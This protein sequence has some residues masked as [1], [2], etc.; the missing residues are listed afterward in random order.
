MHTVV[1]AALALCESFRLTTTAQILLLLFVLRKSLARV[2][3]V[4][5]YLRYDKENN[6]TAVVSVHSK[7]GVVRGRYFTGTADKYHVWEG[8]TIAEGKGKGKREC[9]SLTSEC[10]PV[11]ARNL[12]RLKFPP[13]SDTV[14]LG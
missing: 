13:L 6:S 7:Q 3:G 14:P 5:E 10:A 9:W 4:A 12:L 2:G 11:L 8:S 1:L